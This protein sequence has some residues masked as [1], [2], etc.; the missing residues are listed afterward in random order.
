[1]RYKAEPHSSDQKKIP[2]NLDGID[3]KKVEK[4]LHICRNVLDI[5]RDRVVNYPLPKGKG[6]L[7]IR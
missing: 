3:V 5:R 2:F 6:A 7:E 1:M 4:S